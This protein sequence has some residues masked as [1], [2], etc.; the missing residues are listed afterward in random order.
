MCPDR[1]SAGNVF[2][3]MTMAKLLRKNLR[4]ETTV[5]CGGLSVLRDGNNNG[6]SGL[7]AKKNSLFYWG[8]TCIERGD[9]DMIALGRQSLADPFLPQKYLE[10]REKDI[11]WCVCCNRCGELEAAQERCGC[12]IYNKPYVKL[13]QNLKQKRLPCDI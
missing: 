7:D 4:P 3:H 6:L 2:Q 1:Y 9:F 8:N 12:A 5:I 10:K 11:H 13:Y